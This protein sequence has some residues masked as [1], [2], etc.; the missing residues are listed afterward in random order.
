MVWSMAQ[1]SCQASLKLD[2]HQ[3]VKQVN[4]DED[5]IPVVED[6]NAV[7]EDEIPVVEDENIVIIDG[8]HEDEN[9]DF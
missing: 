9:D 8:V 7:N 3:H 6:G 1:M 5:E 4:V 2:P